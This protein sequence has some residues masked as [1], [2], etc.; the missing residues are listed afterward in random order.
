MN[1][2]LDYSKLNGTNC[3]NAQGKEGDIPDCYKNYIGRIGESD[4]IFMSSPYDK[5][6]RDMFE[7]LGYKYYKNS[8]SI[9][10]THICNFKDSDDT[11]YT[12][13]D[14]ISFI[15]NDELGYFVTTIEEVYCDGYFE[16]STMVAI[17]VDLLK[18]INK[19][20]EELGWDNE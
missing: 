17:T 9:V 2:E 5:T 8:D 14:I 16:Y 10:Y 3:Y 7:K 4:P 19:Q 6:A 20:I 11:N 1:E 18:A 12:H 13:K 15:E